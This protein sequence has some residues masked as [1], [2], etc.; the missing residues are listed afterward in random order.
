MLL[1]EEATD[2]STISTV[3]T[4]N[5]AY[6]DL[7][8]YTNNLKLSTNGSERLRIDSSGTLIHKAAAV[9]N[10]DSND[11]DFRVESNSNTHALFVD[12]GAN[13][14]GFFC[15]GGFGPGGVVNIDNTG[16]STNA[17]NVKSAT[18]NYA[19]TIANTNN[20]DLIWFSVDGS[21]SVGSITGTSSGVTYNT[22]SDRRLKDNI[23]PIADA[24]DKLMSMKPVTHGWKADPEADAVHGFIA[25]EMQDIVP[26]AVSG[27]PDGEEMMSM[28]YG[29][30]T[31]IIVG[32]LQ[33]AHNKIIELEN[34]LKELGDK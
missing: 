3:N 34:K 31:P 19:M 29:R 7:N 28:D 1:S 33:D 10:E 20:G 11:A 2:T 9:F 21:S 24:T 17:L 16:N 5:S 6:S 27:D 15:S 30:I 12:A 26:E 22:T 13:E 25:Q 23:Q 18:G 4:A 14:I 32:A 8:V